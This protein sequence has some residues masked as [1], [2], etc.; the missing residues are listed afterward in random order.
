MN[1]FLDCIV[2]VTLPVLDGITLTE[3]AELRDKS[4]AVRE[5][6]SINVEWTRNPG[7]GIFDGVPD[8]NEL[9]RRF[10]CSAPRARML[11]DFEVLCFRL[12]RIRLEAVDTPVSRKT[13]GY[14]AA[15]EEIL[16]ILEERL[17]RAVNGAFNLKANKDQALE[18]FTEVFMDRVSSLEGTTEGRM[19]RFYFGIRQTESKIQ[20]SDLFGT[21]QFH[22][23]LERRL[24]KK[25]EAA[26]SASSGSAPPAT[27]GSVPSTSEAL[28]VPPAGLSE[29]Y[30]EPP[31][32][33]RAEDSDHWKRFQ[34]GQQREGSISW[35]ASFSALGPFF[36]VRI[37]LRRGLYQEILDWL[38]E[39]EGRF[40][41]E[42]PRILMDCLRTEEN[43]RERKGQTPELLDQLIE[44]IREIVGHR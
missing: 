11:L 6:G 12:I 7:D 29:S 41:P 16:V 35:D 40:S 23:V 36:T 5:V 42:L 2:D 43:L 34:Q 24:W 30:P 20:D 15:T 44:T 26:A 14:I 3:F 1:D 19:V 17:R 32:N 21:Q 18:Q 38:L 31:P 9:A 22:E 28:S 37:L 33:T 13:E 27:E 25:L 10:G 39:K 8:E 4:R